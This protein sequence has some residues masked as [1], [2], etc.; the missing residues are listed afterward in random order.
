MNNYKCV[1]VRICCFIYKMCN[2]YLMQFSYVLRNTLT[3][4]G[5]IKVIKSDKI[6]YKKKMLMLFY[7]QIHLKIL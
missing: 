5:C 3:Q 1:C 2:L 6:S 7:W 4:R